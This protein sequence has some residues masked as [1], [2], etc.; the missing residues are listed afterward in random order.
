MSKLI[1]Q[2]ENGVIYV[3]SHEGN[4]FGIVNSTKII[5]EDGI[6]ISENPISVL[7]LNDFNVEQDW[8]NEIAY[9]DFTE[10][11]GEVSRLVFKGS[12]V[13]LDI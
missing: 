13:Y 12:E 10:E 7:E 8:D 2:N 1:S 4:I 6:T 9:I 11:N 3:E 5:D